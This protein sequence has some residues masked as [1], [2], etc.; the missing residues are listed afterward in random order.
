M[1]RIISGFAFFMVFPLAVTAQ[2]SN[3]KGHE[4]TNKF[5][6]MYDL[7]ATPN[8]YRTASGAPGPE[9]YQ[10]QAD[11]KIDVELD[12]KNTRLYGV[13]TITYHNNAK[14]SLDYLWIQLDQN[15]KART[16]KSPLINDDKAVP[17]IS[18]PNFSRKYL[19]QKFDGGF[20]IDYVKDAL[21][22]PLPYTTNETM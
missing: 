17:S 14:E 1:K 9:Y 4:D 2:E 13:E 11:Y 22:K 5:R 18:A 12:D 3:K 16:S 8:M 19:E 20:R 21:G 7:L 6:Q 15:E 10:Q